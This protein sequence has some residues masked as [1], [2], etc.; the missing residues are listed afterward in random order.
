M[1]EQKLHLGC[2]AHK[3]ISITYN[4]NKL[5]KTITNYLK[6]INHET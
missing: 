6:S 4:K 5:N 2:S 1:A 3:Y